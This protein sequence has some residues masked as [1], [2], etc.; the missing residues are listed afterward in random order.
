MR[1]RILGAGTGAG[2]NLEVQELE[3][4]ERVSGGVSPPSLKALGQEGGAPSRSSG[5]E[6]VKL[7]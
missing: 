4:E 7:A 6:R 5:S 2:A 1:V 3:V